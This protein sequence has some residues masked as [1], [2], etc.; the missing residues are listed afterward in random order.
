MDISD[1]DL[2]DTSLCIGEFD[3]FRLLRLNTKPMLGTFILSH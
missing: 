1:D 2:S 3:L